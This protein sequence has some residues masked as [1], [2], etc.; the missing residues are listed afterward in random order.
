MSIG[1]VFF[2]QFITNLQ[3]FLY[4]ADAAFLQQAVAFY[5]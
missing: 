2:L 3:F 4:W 1:A 5:A